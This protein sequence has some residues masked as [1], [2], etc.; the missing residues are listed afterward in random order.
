MLQ[1]GHHSNYSTIQ[2]MNKKRENLNVCVFINDNVPT[3][4]SNLPGFNL[5]HPGSRQNG[6]LMWQR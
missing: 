5:S 3:Q 2:P 4:I 1:A 6:M